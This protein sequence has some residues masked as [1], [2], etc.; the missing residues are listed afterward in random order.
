[1]CDLKDVQ[2]LRFYKFILLYSVNIHE[3]GQQVKPSENNRGNDIKLIKRQGC[4]HTIGQHFKTVYLSVFSH[5]ESRSA[6][7]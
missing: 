2:I 6:N 5:Y 1:M 7:I 4:K 3:K